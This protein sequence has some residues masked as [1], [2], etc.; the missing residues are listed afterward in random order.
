MKRSNATTYGTTKEQ[1]IHFLLHHNREI[2]KITKNNKIVTSWTAYREILECD[3]AVGVD[4]EFLCR[5]RTRLLQLGRDEHTDGAQELQLRAV[6]GVD[7]QEA[8]HVVHRQREDFLLATL[9]LAHL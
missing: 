5:Q 1:N 9:L 7:R 2:K 4:D 8:I 3:G 6:D